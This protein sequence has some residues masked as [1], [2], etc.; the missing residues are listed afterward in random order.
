MDTRHYDAAEAKYI[1]MNSAGK[2]DEAASV[3]L[4]RELSQVRRKVLE[5]PKA[6]LT[7]FQVFPVQTEVAAGAET[8]F[9]RIY[10]DVGMAKIIGDYADDLPRV[11]IVA[12]EVPVKV[13]GIG[14]AY[15]YTVNDIRHAQFA[16]VNLTARKALAVRRAIDQKLNRLAWQG[17]SEHNIIGFLNNPNITVYLVPADGN[18]NSGANSTQFIHKT[19]EQIINNMNEFLRAIPEAT[20]E[21]EVPDTVLLPPAVYDKLATTARTTNSDLTVMEF[22]QK[23]HPEIR[24]WIKVGE[25]K[26]AGTNGK[27]VMFA[28]KFEP[29]YVQFEIPLRFEQLPVERRNLEFV[30]NCVCR[31]IGVTVSYPNAFVKA[32]GV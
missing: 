19:V 15:G 18:Q 6:P 20:N 14:A 31:A 3:F 17:D 5:V 23:T 1:E 28:G 12:K 9:Q 32:E 8:A 2:M 27:A 11:D 29:D 7:A 26:D 4:A 25:L 10:D 16:G 24:R 30:V 21:I 22:L 13:K